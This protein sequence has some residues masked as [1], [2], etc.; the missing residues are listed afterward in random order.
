MDNQTHVVERRCPHVLGGYDTFVFRYVGI[1]LL[2]RKTL[3]S[4]NIVV[5]MERV[6]FKWLPRCFSNDLVHGSWWFVVGSAVSTMIP[7]IPLIDLSYHFFNIPPSSDVKAFDQPFTWLLL[8]S[9]GLFFTLGSFALVLH[10]EENQ[11][12]EHFSST[13]THEE[14]DA[15]VI[16]AWLFFLGS[17]PF[18]PYTIAFLINQPGEV[19]S[20]ALK[21][22]LLNVW[23]YM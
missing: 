20:T 14:D 8:I 22:C 18:I 17:I 7:V 23:Q 19:M 21:F 5:K 2:R 1:F 9:S 4:Q 11:G 6:S 16:A 10:F 15:A 3:E 12:D 13:D